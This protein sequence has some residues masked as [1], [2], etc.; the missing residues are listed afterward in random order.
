MYLTE[1]PNCD[2]HSLFWNKSKQVYECVACDKTY[3]EPTLLEA[4][5]KSIR[6]KQCPTCRR[7]TCFD[8]PRIE[9]IKCLYKQCG[10]EF[11][12][13]QALAEEAAYQI[14]LAQKPYPNLPPANAWYP[15]DPY[16]K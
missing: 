1:C 9:K 10:K 16:E 14:H 8:D 4:V 7:M 3:T 5:R 11:T 15:N 13:E 2:K 6:L 12:P